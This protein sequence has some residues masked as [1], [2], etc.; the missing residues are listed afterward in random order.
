[1]L[2]SCD[3][4]SQASCLLLVI[5][6]FW[7]RNGHYHLVTHV[8]SILNTFRSSHVVWEWEYFKGIMYWVPLSREICPKDTMANLTTPSLTYLLR[9]SCSSYVFFPKTEG[10]ESMYLHMVSECAPGE[11]DSICFLWIGYVSGNHHHHMLIMY[12]G[13]QNNFTMLRRKKRKGR[14]EGRDREQCVTMEENI[15]KH[16]SCNQRF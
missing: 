10:G 3:S 5:V 9:G 12:H 1:M 2:C 14:K 15:Q 16:I 4:Y 11:L 13:S 7:K 8:L 6:L